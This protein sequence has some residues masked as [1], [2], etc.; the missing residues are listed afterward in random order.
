MKNDSTAQ[1]GT[2]VSHPL[3]DTGW[4][5]ISLGTKIKSVSNA[6]HIW[7]TIQSC[8]AYQNSTAESLRNV[9]HF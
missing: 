4:Q 9:V 8:N 3:R 2:H 7:D 1:V 5:T 6:V